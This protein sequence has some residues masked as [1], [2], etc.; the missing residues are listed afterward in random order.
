MS[1]SQLKNFDAVSVFSKA[2]RPST[3]NQKLS[4]PM[5][6]RKPLEADRKTTTESIPIEDYKALT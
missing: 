2:S 1:P 6:A 3:A 5:T 4:R